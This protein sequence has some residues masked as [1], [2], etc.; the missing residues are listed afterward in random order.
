[1]WTQ[2]FPFLECLSKDSSPLGVKADPSREEGIQGLCERVWTQAS[3]PS[4]KVGETVDKEVLNCV[5]GQ[6]STIGCQ[7]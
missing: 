5:Q 1:M 3:V 2:G 6:R 4:F 7:V